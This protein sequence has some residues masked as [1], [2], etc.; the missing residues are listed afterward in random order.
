MGVTIH[1]SCNGC[2]AEVDGTRSLRQE[3]VPIVP[4]G[5]F[6]YYQLPD[7]SALVPDGW[8]AWDPYTQATYC[9]TCW[10]SIKTDP[11]P[12]AQGTQEAKA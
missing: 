10:A 7:V 12:S 9:P 3:F 6:G 5:S 2:D 11:E 8:V 4:G 1:L